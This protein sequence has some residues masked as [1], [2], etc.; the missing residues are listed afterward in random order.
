MDT[1]RCGLAWLTVGVGLA[2]LGTPGVARACTPNAC[3]TFSDFSLFSVASQEVSVDGVILFESEEWPLP[4]GSIGGALNR[5]DVVVVDSMGFEVPGALEAVPGVYVWRPNAPLNPGDDLW[6]TYSVTPQVESCADVLSGTQ[7]V[8]VVNA[9][10]PTL[11]KPRVHFE[12]SFELFHDEQ[13]E[14]LVCCDEAIPSRDCGHTH[15]SQGYCAAE[16]GIGLALADAHVSGLDPALATTTRL[17][18]SVDG[19]LLTSRGGVAVLRGA[20]FSYRRDHAYEVSVDLV[21]LASGERLNLGTFQADGHRPRELGRVTI[22]VSEKI[23]ANCAGPAYRCGSSGFWEEDDCS[24][25]GNDGD[26][27]PTGGAGESTTGDVATTTGVGSGSSS[28]G[29]ESGSID[30]GAADTTAGKGCAVGSPGPFAFLVL[31]G[32]V[33]RRAGTRS[34]PGLGR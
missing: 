2:V 1:L 22:D 28:G 34:R 32:F 8:A 24:P 13:I 4:F 20:S 12:T 33:A 23:D 27:T 3:D 31:F 21:D 9:P 5:I 18:F 26:G 29:S 30:D 10:P 6:V 11:A 17:D 25:Y 16:R 14:Y 19:E 15:W 7:S